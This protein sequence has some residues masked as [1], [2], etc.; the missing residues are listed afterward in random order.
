MNKIYIYL[1]GEEELGEIIERIRNA[2][3]KEIILVVSENTKALLHPVN[4]E[5]FKK[6][7]ENLN[8]KVYFDTTDEKL[9][10]LAKAHGLNIFL[11][12]FEEKKIVDIRPPKKTTIPVKEE[13]TP[14]KIQKTRFSFKINLSKI[15][16]Y[17]FSLIFVFL[18]FVFI[19]QIFQTRAE[20]NIEIT[21]TNLEPEPLVI[22]L[23]S[24]ALKPDY[25]NKILPAQYEKIE[26]YKTE[27]V[28]TTGKIFEEERPLLKVVFLNFTEK[29]IPLVSGT[30]VSYNDNI[31]RTTERIV[32][33]PFQ[34][35]EPGK[36]IVTAF[37][38]NIKDEKLFILKDSDLIIPALEGK[39]NEEGKYW[40]DVLKAKVAEDYNLSSKTK[41]GSVAPE[42][43]TNVKLALEN[44]LKSAIKTELSIKYPQ[45]FYYFDPSL[46]KIEIQNVSHNVG[47]KTDKISATG[48]ATYETLV[49]SKKEFDDFIRNL[50]NQE[51]LKQNKNL[52]IENLTYEKIEL[53]DFDSKKRTMTLGISLRADLIPDLNPEAIK[54]KIKGQTLDFVKDYFSKIPEV[55]SVKIKIFPQW[56]ETLPQDIRRIKINFE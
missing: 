19:W 42:D 15:F 55:K 46:V 52:V 13:I 34:N 30:R 16:T 1:K 8:K 9:I 44:S 38:D 41:I 21:K 56:K 28:T 47:E 24:D 45:S 48:K 3:E 11:S 40:S 43:V 4:L 2:K 7:I 35:N 51:I 22:T 5:V 39:R 26:L 36:I 33:P 10:N 29:E 32:I 50:I 6:E 31:F 25:E 23:K 49:V 18:F 20:I 12:E 37:P 14:Q 27:I 53:L 54:D 17:I